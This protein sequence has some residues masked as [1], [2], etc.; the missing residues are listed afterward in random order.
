MF[1]IRDEQIETFRRHAIAR[2]E[3]SMVM[4]LL[5][6]YPQ[7][8]ASISEG[9]LR[10]F[11]RKG[12]QKARRQDVETEEAVKILL[13]MMTRFGEDFGR[14]PD[15]E[16][17]HEILAHPDLPGQ[18]KVDLIQDRLVDLAEEESSRE[19]NDADSETLIA[20]RA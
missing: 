9:D 20:E 5:A 7:H 3:D 13:E 17:I 14:F 18:L 19:K 11:I 6:A 15:P 2:F 16:W 10:A 1:C 12:I 8:F 4:H